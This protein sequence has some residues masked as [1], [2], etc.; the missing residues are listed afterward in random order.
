MAESKKNIWYASHDTKLGRIFA[1]ATIKGL[2][3]ISINSGKKEFL[4]RLKEKRPGYEFVEDQ[5][6]FL[7]V[8]KELD[9][10]LCGKPV[11][12]NIPLDLCGSTFELSVWKALKRIPRGRTR[13]YKEVAGLL[14][15]PGA[16]R[17]VGNAC[18]KN[19][20]PIIIP[21]HRVIK[22]N[23][24]MGGYTG[25]VEIKKTLLETEGRV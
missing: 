13:S 17:A 6:R 18:G 15:K 20:V 4:E 14:K 16:A 11:I 8:F 10:Y 19:P 1:A 22:G 9:R 24:D 25:G 12:F 21:C 2:T 7:R 5:R 23:G 3:D